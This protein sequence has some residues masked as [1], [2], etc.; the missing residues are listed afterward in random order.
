M[1]RPPAAFRELGVLVTAV[2]LGMSPWFSATVVAGPMAQEWGVS[3]SRAIWLTLGVQLGFVLGSLVSASLLLADRLQPR[4]LAAWSAA[5]AAISTTLLVLPGIGSTTAVLLRIIVGMALAGVYPPGIKIAAGWTRARRG[6][7]IG[8]LVAGTALG[9]AAPHLMRLS[10]APDTWRGL[11]L[12]AAASA[13]L[14]ALRFAFRV[15]EGP[16]QAPS[17]PFD[18]RA[19][20]LVARNRAVVLATGGYLGH[21]WELYAMWSS[22]GAFWAFVARERGLEA[23]VGSATAFA[24]V[25]AGALGSIWAGWAADRMGRSVVTILAMAVSGACSLLI[26]FAL[27]A[28]LAVLITLALVWGAA[29]VADS[30]QFSASVT[31]FAHHDYVGTAVTVQTALGF[32]LT[33]L[34]I[35]LI[36]AWVGAW[37]W[38]YAYMP[39]AIGPALGIAAMAKLRTLERARRVAAEE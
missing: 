10:V 38:K 12:L 4:R 27:D 3:P 13:A 16:Y 11:Q 14:G 32:L 31:E 39:L 36:P 37:G 35:G 34:T 9:S 6:L 23:W 5:T 30:A 28:P 29:I 33:M 2:V 19:L 17:A 20:Q 15:R 21:M 25:G 7:A 8:L 22:I 26:G 1:T 18:P 24:T